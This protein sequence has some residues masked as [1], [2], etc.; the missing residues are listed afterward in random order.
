MMFHKVNFQVPGQRNL[1]VNEAF[2][3]PFLYGFIQ[4]ANELKGEDDAET[5]TAL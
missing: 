1:H 5:N 4:C 3:C 2:L